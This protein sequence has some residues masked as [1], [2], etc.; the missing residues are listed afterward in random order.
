MNRSPYSKT[1][2]RL[3]QKHRF[4]HSVQLSPYPARTYNTPGFAPYVSMNHLYVPPE[5]PVIPTTAADL[6]PVVRENAGEKVQNSTNKV[7]DRDVT[8]LKKSNDNK[9]EAIGAGRSLIIQAEG[10]GT[11]VNEVEAGGEQ[12]GAGKNAE[13]SNIDVGEKE[14][15]GEKV[16]EENER[17][18]SS[19]GVSDPTSPPPPSVPNMAVPK[20]VQKVSKEQFNKLLPKGL[21]K[22][23]LQN[24]EDICFTK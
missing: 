10:A 13:E 7:L 18:I 22:K 16:A 12:E 5:F 11:V 20:K 21:K 14:G 2:K 15:Q 9:K 23:S 19:V 17:D 8:F 3:V 1:N 4:I 24:Y 6:Y